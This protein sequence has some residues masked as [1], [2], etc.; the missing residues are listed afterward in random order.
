M[1]GRIGYSAATG[2]MVIMLSWF[3]IISLMLAIDPGGRD[4]ADPAL[5]RHVD[6]RA[7]VPD[8][9]EDPRARDRAVADA[10]S[11]RWCKTLMDG[12]LAA[13]G[14]TRRHR[15]RQA[16]Q[17][18]RSLSGLQILGGGSILT[19]L[20]LGAIGAFV[21]DKKFV[22]PRLRLGGRRADLL[23]LHAR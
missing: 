11:R 10:A 14:T 19:G 17:C 15:L 20:V 22:K 12:A 5:H 13:A 6:R 2:I 9:A 1:G 23:R 3:G 18:R 4:L 8:H 16:R 21:I 7:G